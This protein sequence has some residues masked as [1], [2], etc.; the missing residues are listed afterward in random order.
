MKTILITTNDDILADV[1]WEYF[2]KK[3]TKLLD[4][5]IVLPSRNEIDFP[6]FFKPFIAIKMLGIKGLYKF[7]LYKLSHSKFPL[8]SVCVDLVSFNHLDYEKIFNEV[9]ISK[10]DILISVGAPILFKPDL[11]SIPKCYSLNLHNGDILK[12]RGHFSTFWEI[13]N[14][15]NELTLTLHEMSEIADSGNIY[16][17]VRI[18][19]NLFKTFWDLM[20]WKKKAGGS[21]LAENLNFLENNE[22][23]FNQV[24]SKHD[25]K[26]AKHYPFPKLQDVLNFNFH[27]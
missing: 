14:K 22:I 3:R 16:D 13:F 10:C 6:K 9:K 23:K 26:N 25:L 5:I 15:E 20:Y 1:F 27:Y 24:M 7:V 17:Q 2:T 21:M 11:L 4:K 19:K 18:N 12:Y 8:S